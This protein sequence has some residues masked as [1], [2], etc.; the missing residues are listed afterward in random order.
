MTV[1]KNINIVSSVLFSGLNWIF[2]LNKT[3]DINLLFF[4]RNKDF[5]S[6][7]ISVLVKD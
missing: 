1:I 2:L 3:K 4:E 5:I 7:V 6:P